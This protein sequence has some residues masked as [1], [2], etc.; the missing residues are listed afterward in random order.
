MHAP[1]FLMGQPFVGKQADTLHVRMSLWVAQVS[2]K[3]L[4]NRVFQHVWS[5]LRYYPFPFFTVPKHAWLPLAG[6]NPLT[7]LFLYKDKLT[8]G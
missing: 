1:V 5:F 3:G 8:K 2:L 6:I 7:P 4:Y